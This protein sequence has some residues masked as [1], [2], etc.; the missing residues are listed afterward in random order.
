MALVREPMVLYDGGFDASEAS[1]FDS[2]GC[3]GHG[4]G[5]DALLG[6]VDAA[7]LFGGYAHD[8]PAGASASAYVKDGSHWAG[9][10][11]SVLAFDRAARGHG[12]QAMATAAAQEE[13]ECDAWIDAMDED[14]GEAAPAPSIGFDP[15]TGCFSLTQRP[16]AGARRPFGLLFPSASGGAPS[17]D[18][19]AP[20]PASRGSQKRPSAGI[21]RAQ[22]AE[23]RASKKQCGA[24]RKTTAKAKS[25]AP[26]ITS[27]KDPQSLAAKNRREKIS[28]RLRT[29]QEMVPNGTKVDMVTMLEKAISYVK[30]LQLQVKVLATDEFWP[31]QGGMAPEISQV[32]EA[33]DAILSSQRGQFNCS[34]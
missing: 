9:V 8:E 30:F 31:A 26:A 13:E 28:E 12:A 16:G 1:A 22:D 32:K 19:A 21:A 23:P 6:G 11:A 3:F 7:A 15:A 27:P 24:S 33:L 17:P 29:L 10:G 25:P 4:H 34:S 2:I 20:A 14:N 18:S 5:H